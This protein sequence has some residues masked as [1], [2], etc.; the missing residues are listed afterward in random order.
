MRV[1]SLVVL[2]LAG[3][4][5]AAC[6]KQAPAPESVPVELSSSAEKQDLEYESC[7]CRLGESLVGEQAHILDTGLRD[8]LT[9]WLCLASFD[10]VSRPQALSDWPCLP[11]SDEPETPVADCINSD[12]GVVGL[13]LGSSR[14][15]FRVW[16][17]THCHFKLETLARQRLVYL[18]AATSEESLDVF[19]TCARTLPSEEPRLRHW[20][21][22]SAARG[23]V[24]AALSWTGD[25]G[26]PV[27]PEKG[28]V[29]AENVLWAKE[30]LQPGVSLVD[31]AIEIQLEDRTKSGTFTLTGHRDGSGRTVA[32][33]AVFHLPSPES[34]PAKRLYSLEPSYTTDT[35]LASVVYPSIQLHGHN[36]TLHLVAR[37]RPAKPARKLRNLDIG[38]GAFP[39]YVELYKGSKRIARSDLGDAQIFI[40]SSFCGES[41]RLEFPL[42]GED[43]FSLDDLRQATNFRL[44]LGK[45][46]RGSAC[47]R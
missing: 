17:S 11:S 30:S 26:A 36:A 38:D 37:A 35:G 31:E 45:G 12:Y 14:Y 47:R 6:Q 7:T 20:L 22:P 2:G 42:T 8:A 18:A 46:R 25:D 4:F 15:A 43:G 13:E 32:Y 40:P 16:K 23:S 41:Y 29:E 39:F 1:R 5:A 9:D 3:L 24:A 21:A 33:P 28:G 10:E 19:Q 34:F 27:L 44:S